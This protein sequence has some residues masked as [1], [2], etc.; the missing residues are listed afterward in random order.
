M[1][2][3]ITTLVLSIALS[4]SAETSL[5]I[6]RGQRDTVFSPNHT[7]VA[8]TAPGNTAKINGEAV[9]VYK[10]GA[11]GGTVKLRPGD[12]SI[13]VAVSDG[14]TTKKKTVNVYLKDAPTEKKAPAAEA[15]FV[16]FDTPR[17]F[18]TAD[19]AY[20]QYGDGGDRLGGSKMGYLNNGIT[21]KAVGEKG[22]L[23][24]IALS[25]NRYAYMPKDCLKEPGTTIQPVN[26]GSW[27]ISN[28]GNKDRI[29]ISLPCRLP[30]RSWVQLDPTTICI[31]LFGAMNNSNWITQRGD[32]GI[33]EYVDC[34]QPESDVLKVVIKLKD[35]YSW[36][37][38]VNYDGNN[39]VIDVNHTPSLVLK[40]LTIG[41]D[42]GH[43]GKYPGA[44]S[45][46]GLT[47]KEVNLDMI[48]R[49][50]K[51]LASKGAKVVLSR[52]GDT[53]PSMIERKQIFLDND[54][55]LMIS[56]HNNSGGSPLTTMGTSTFY[57]HISNRELATCMLNRLL[58][59]G[60]KNFGMTGN[61]NF[62]LNSPTEYPNVL[63]EVLFMSS[64]PEE[65]LLAD[66]DFRQQVAEKAVLGLEDYL[67][68]V[69]QSLQKH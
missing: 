46:T 62:S 63:L 48:L 68:K 31:E 40:D 7:I 55:D 19:W 51:I 3:L 6:T 49:I 8:V 57:K 53:G 11:F 65:E 45:A 60:L 47:E 28:R 50:A 16:E 32:L 17:Y 23:Y 44:K 14:N 52:D 1:K 24:K 56:L 21:V 26:T 2:K 20:L 37:Y 34:Q 39:L 10:T 35:K 64:L 67:T 69:K 15:A 36:G 66:P 4:A 13:T 18:I 27:S 42:A 5:E 59:L 33:I 43:G 54:V 41:L 25:Q 58:E 30:Y 12:N 29:S 61:F 22:N 38:S 9:H